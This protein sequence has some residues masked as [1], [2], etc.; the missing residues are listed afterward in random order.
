MIDWLFMF[1]HMWKK[2]S[3]LWCISHRWV[4]IVKNAFSEI[5]ITTADSCCD[6]CALIEK[7]N[8]KKKTKIHYKCF[9]FSLSFSFKD[10]MVGGLAAW[11]SSIFLATVEIYTEQNKDSDS[12]ADIAYFG[13]VKV[14]RQCKKKREIKGGGGS[15]LIAE[16]DRRK[17]FS[18]QWYCPAKSE[19]WGSMETFPLWLSGSRRRS[20]RYWISKS[21]K[22]RKR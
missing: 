11:L 8:W 20:R 7:N 9:L 3:L 12:K 16:V 19:H 13:T 1:L 15:A 21:R 4:C 17:Q 2:L 5:C 10:V 14:V 6:N 18:L 22:K